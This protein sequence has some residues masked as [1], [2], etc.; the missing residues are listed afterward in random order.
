MEQVLSIVVVLTAGLGAALAGAAAN[1]TVKKSNNDA[2]K[3]PD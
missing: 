3:R 1:L 2:N